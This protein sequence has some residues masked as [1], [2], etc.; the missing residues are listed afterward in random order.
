MTLTKST[1]S[2]SRA[3]LATGTAVEV[4]ETVPTV[5]TPIKIRGLELQNRFVVSP[6]GTWSAQDGHL[7]DFHLVHLGAFAF[8]G[9][10]LTVVESTAVAANGRTSPQDSGLWQDSQ[11]AP[12]K[13]VADFVHAQGQK[14]GIQLN[15]AGVKA[16]M[17][18]PRFLPKGELKVATE[19][20]G[21][22]PE[23]VWGPSTIPY[24]EAHITPKALT[25]K[26]IE[27]LIQNFADAARRAV[28]AGLGMRSIP[29]SQKELRLIKDNRLY[30]DSWSSWLPHQSIP[31]TLD[32]SA[33]R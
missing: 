4:D 13:L 5:F 12:L 24:T 16:G 7:T 30:R 27:T 3:S 9:A 11:V 18:A 33:H 2:L 22:W 8:R 1:P 29:L 14:I 25:I 31:I 32:K 20:E 19:Q 28:E 10:A 17:V 15:H 26:G 21:G 6:M 23:D